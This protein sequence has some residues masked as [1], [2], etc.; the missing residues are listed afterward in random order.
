MA[1]SDWDSPYSPWAVRIYSVRRTGAQAAQHPFLG[2]TWCVRNLDGVMAW[3]VLTAP[4]IADLVRL[5][6]AQDVE[7]EICNMCTCSGDGTQER[8]V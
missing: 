4:S 3:G 7:E 5:V 8:A 2:H 6:K 1:H